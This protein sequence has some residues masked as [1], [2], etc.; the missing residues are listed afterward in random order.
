MTTQEK[1]DF[2]RAKME[3]GKIVYNILPDQIAV[4]TLYVTTSVLGE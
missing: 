1:I 2:I 3:E 4:S